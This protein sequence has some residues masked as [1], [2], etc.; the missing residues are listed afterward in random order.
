M[1]RQEV[2]TMEPL[3][4]WLAV[5]AGMTAVGYIWLYWHKSQRKKAKRKP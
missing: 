3:K 5:V 1:H 2:T 4:V